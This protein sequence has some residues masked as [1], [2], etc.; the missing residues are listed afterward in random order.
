MR[1]MLTSTT[2]Y[3]NWTARQL[4]LTTAARAPMPVEEEDAPPDEEE[5]T[6]ISDTYDAAR[7]AEGADG[8]PT[9]PT[10]C[11]RNAEVETGMPNTWSRHPFLLINADHIDAMTLGSRQSEN[12]GDR[13]SF[14]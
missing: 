6:R 10:V 1:G 8:E 14:A 12:R 11:L 13:D 7:E 5:R 2:R 9:F 3:G 4:Q